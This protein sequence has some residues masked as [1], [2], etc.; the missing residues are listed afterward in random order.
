MQENDIKDNNY[1]RHMTGNGTD[2]QVEYISEKE[3]DM[4]MN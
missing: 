1:G 2:K 3:I 4:K